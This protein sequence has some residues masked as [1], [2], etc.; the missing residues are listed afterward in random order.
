MSMQDVMSARTVCR[1]YTESDIIV[2][3]TVHTPLHHED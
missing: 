1:C 3:V 2:G